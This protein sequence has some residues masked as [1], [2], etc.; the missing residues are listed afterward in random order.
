MP[1]L[2]RW[3]RPVCSW[4]SFPS[5]DGE[6]ISDTECHDGLPCAYEEAC[7]L[8]MI[9]SVRCRTDDVPGC[10]DLSSIM[11]SMESRR[12]FIESSG[13]PTWLLTGSSSIRPLGL[14]PKSGSIP[15]L[16]CHSAWKRSE[17]Q[18]SQPAS[19]CIDPAARQASSK[20]T[21]PK[22]LVVENRPISTS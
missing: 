10:P 8:R 21:S 6:N 15:S 5:G 19:A 2:M 22:K 18:L 3:L 20:Q 11:A 9:E 4:L 12:P 16:T 13:R 7:P 14:W 17:R 1:K